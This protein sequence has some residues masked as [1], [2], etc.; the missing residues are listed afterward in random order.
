MIMEATKLPLPKC[1]QSF[2]LVGNAATGMSSLTCGSGL[3][4]AFGLFG[5]RVMTFR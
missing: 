1:F 2:Y 3:L 4:L 5:Q